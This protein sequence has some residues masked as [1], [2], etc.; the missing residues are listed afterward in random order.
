[1]VKVETITA[2]ASINPM[3]LS[4]ERPFLLEKFLETKVNV[5]KCPSPEAPYVFTVERVDSENS[6]HVPIR[7]IGQNMKQTST[8]TESNHPGPFF[9]IVPFNQSLARKHRYTSAVIEERLSNE[10]SSFFSSSNCLLIFDSNSCFLLRFLQSSLFSRTCF[11]SNGSCAF[12]FP[13]L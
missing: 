7:T 5:R 6:Q 11:S 8:K 13:H 4:I 10:I 2:M 12:I 9:S 1:M 3:E